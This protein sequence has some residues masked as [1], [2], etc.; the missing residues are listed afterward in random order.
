[1]RSG[2]IELHQEDIDFLRGLMVQLAQTKAKSGDTRTQMLLLMNDIEEMADQLKALLLGEAKTLLGKHVT[3]EQL[4]PPTVLKES[5]AELQ[6][7]M[8]LAMVL[9]R[10]ERTENYSKLLGQIRGMG[11]YALGYLI[12][13]GLNSYY[14]PGL[15]R[16]INE[17]KPGTIRSNA[18]ELTEKLS[19]FQ[20]LARLVR[21]RTTNANMLESM[22]ERRGLG[23]DPSTAARA[24]GSDSI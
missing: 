2:T 5:D 24:A 17:V 12:Q 6:L 9:V 11:D 13:Q 15:L 1:M 14:T 10:L 20:D 23:T 18:L 19:G 21:Q 16:V 4:E 22:R 3:V 8:V 7:A